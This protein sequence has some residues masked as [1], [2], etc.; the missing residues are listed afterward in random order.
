VREDLGF[1]PSFADWVR[2]ENDRTRRKIAAVVGE[3]SRGG[4]RRPRFR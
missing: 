2:I 1:I 4:P 3:G